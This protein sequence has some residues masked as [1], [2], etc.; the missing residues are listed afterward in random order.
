MGSLLFY[1]FESTLCLTIL[2]FLF[3]IFFKADTLFRTNR[4][5]LL[6]GTLCCMILPFMQFGIA[7]NR[8]WQQP[9][10]V[11]RNALIVENGLDAAIN[12]SGEGAS[13]DITAVETSE[14]KELNVTDAYSAQS[15]SPFSWSVALGVLYIIG[16]GS[17]LLFFL[18]STWRMWRLI[19]H[20]P[21]YSCGKYKLLIYPEKILSFS[22]GNTIVLS[23][24]DYDKYADEILLHEQMH[25][26]YRHTLDLLWMEILLVLHWFNP[27]AWLL[28]RDLRELH[29]F[30]A[31]N[32]VLTHG[33]DATQYQLLLVKK[34]VGTRLYSMAN[35]FNHSKLK[36]RINMMLKKRTNSWAR[37]KLL[38]FVP[39]A[40]GTLIAFAQPE[41]KKTV[42]QVVKPER[43][44]QDSI[45]QD[46][47]ESLKQYF[48]QK[49]EVA[50]KDEDTAKKVLITQHVFFVN[51]RNAMMLD[52]N[53]IQ[54]VED[55]RAAFAKQ[56]KADYQMAKKEG[57]VPWT[58]LT[59]RYD[60]GA[61]PQ[62]LQTYLTTIKEVYHRLHQEISAELG[63]VDE[64]RLDKT[65]PVMVYLAEPV[66]YI[67]RPSS[68][69]PLPMRFFL[70]YGDGSHAK[71]LSDITLENLEK[72]LV[73]YKASAGDESIVASWGVI[74]GG[75]GVKTLNEVKQL[76]HKTLGTDLGM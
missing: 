29:E 14:D 30:E 12:R 17:T 38:L 53:H 26:H 54:N 22:W 33:I 64:V 65:L 57:K 66:K 58:I 20:H 18:L 41:V 9:V 37:L 45:P 67:P 63:G 73:A 68:K 59:V 44:K 75:V 15:V 48:G 23:Q 40:A 47:L 27:A 42:E 61:T 35:G 36:N 21:K 51:M 4:F 5:I 31:D 56:L 62:T 6:G 60:S 19:C 11:V 74:G 10:S 2:Y 69:D 3:R 24:E 1:I 7:E 55:L 52:D 50:L 43:V 32:G 72:E 76:F 49:Y 28:M 70:S 13:K 39:V 25:L 8:L 16:A 46:G 71:V 34:S